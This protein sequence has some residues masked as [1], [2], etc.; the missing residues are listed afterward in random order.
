M[1]TYM[2]P[3]AIAGGGIIAALALALAAIALP[4][5]AQVARSITIA[6]PPAQVFALVNSPARFDR[7]NPFRASDP[8]LQTS[9][10]GPAA[11]P[12]ATLRWR[13][14]EGE[15][16][17]TIIAAQE[18]ARVDMALDLGPMGQ[19]SQSFVL[20]PT[21]AGTRVTWTTT[22]RFG[23]DP[24]QRAFGLGMD[25]MLGPVYERGL[26]DL[27]VLAEQAA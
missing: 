25:G 18:N 13:G 6:A 8:A 27:K 17:Q 23:P 7:F 16:V 1:K 20:E 14:K 3:L 15:G 21:A 26:R 5:Q 2:K 10:G 22:A 19:P 4:D 12:G 24:I 9:Y 11:G